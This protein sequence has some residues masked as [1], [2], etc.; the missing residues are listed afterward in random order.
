MKQVRLVAPQTVILEE[1]E[2]PA[3]ADTQ[4]LI[5]VKRIGVCGSDIHAYYDKHPYISC[6]IV[7]GHEF[8][9]EIVETGERVKAL[10][11]GDRVTVIPQLVCGVCHPCT[12]GS[13]HIC[14]ELKVIGC[15]ADGAAREFIPVDQELV[16][17]LPQD[18]SFDHGAMVEPVAVG[19]HAVRRLGDVSGMKILVLGAGPIGNLA[20]QVAKGLGAAAVMITDVSAFRLEKARDC[21]IDQVVNVAVELLESRIDSAFGIDRADAILECAGVQDTIEQA[22]GLARKGTD[23]IVVGVFAERPM[24]DL[25]LV[26][27]KELRLIGTLMYKAEDYRTAIE[28]IQSGSVRLDPLITKHFPFQEY[29]DAYKYIEEYGDRSQKVLIDLDE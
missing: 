28:L 15:Q 20:A 27:D 24:V 9:G 11:V 29:A 6:P 3:P 10:A 5:R 7:Q 17:K 26:Q 14:N 19:V 22:I 13:Y 21:G 25:G 12:H 4:V 18:M 1:V 2:K 16:V 23:I 8:S